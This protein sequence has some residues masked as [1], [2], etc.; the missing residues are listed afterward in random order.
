MLELL[1]SQADAQGH[2]NLDWVGAWASEL[3]FS[4]TLIAGGVTLQDA[5][6]LALS[7]PLGLV[8]RAPTFV[9]PRVKHCANLFRSSCGIAQQGRQGFF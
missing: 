3:T 9:E 6:L 4:A 7:W 2:K 1:A 5:L 8:F